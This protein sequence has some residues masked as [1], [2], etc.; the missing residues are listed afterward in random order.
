MCIEFKFFFYLFAFSFITAA[1]Q[2]LDQEAIIWSVY[3]RGAWFLAFFWK[4]WVGLN[5][6]GEIFRKKAAGTKWI[7]NFFSAKN[8]KNPTKILNFRV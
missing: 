3:D 8:P 7:E 1:D 2:D 4:G 6:A 5:F